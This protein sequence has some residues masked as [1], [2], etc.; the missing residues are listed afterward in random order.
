MSSIRHSFR[1]RLT[2][3]FA[4]FGVL[5]SLLLS[6]GLFVAT[7]SLGLRLMDETLGS[8]IDDFLSRRHVNPRALLP[9]T[10]TIRGYVHLHNQPKEGLAPELANLSPGQYQMTLN[11]IPYRIDVVDRGEERFVMM[12]NATQQQYREWTFLSYT[13][14]GTLLMTLFSAWLGW[15]LAGRIVKPISELSRRVSV[16]SPED[17]EQNISRGFSDDEVGKLAGVFGSYLNRM[18]E[19]IARERE[20]IARERAFT[21]DVSHELRTPLTVVQ[22]VVELMESDCNYVDNKQQQRVARIGRA[23]REMIDITAALLLMAREE[24]LDEHVVQQCDVWD[25]VS[26]VVD[27]NDHLVSPKTSIQL[28]CL[29]RLCVNAERTLLLI[30][31]ANLIRNA[32]TYTPSGSVTIS[33]DENSLTISDTGS[34]ITEGE[35]GRIFERYAKGADSKG[36]GIGLSLVKRICDRYGW[37]IEIKSIVGRG[38]DARLIF[39]GC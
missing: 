38:T 10:I 6:T 35:I 34:G 13:A 8:E 36:I 24:N 11:N 18:R 37:V 15:W 23:N 20:F 29:N 9:A 19:L 12:F 26:N 4:I 21:A 31:V 22:G 16:A 30:V 27:V 7:H 33:L 14:V 5:V 32:F 2:F 25:V 3:T 17:K 1:F 28:N 39:T